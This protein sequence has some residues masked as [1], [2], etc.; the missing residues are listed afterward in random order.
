[1]DISHQ[2]FLYTRSSVN[3]RMKLDKVDN[4]IAIRF[5]H[6][7]S[8]NR[9][10]QLHTHIPILNITIDR[11]GKIKTNECGMIFE[12]ERFIRELYHQELAYNLRQ[13]GYPIIYA[14]KL[15]QLAPEIEGV[16][17]ELM[18]IFSSRRQQIEAYARDHELDLNN[19][20]HM[21]MATLATRKAK[22]NSLAID[23]LSTI[24]QEKVKELG[25]DK[26]KFI[27]E[28]YDNRNG[29]Y[30]A[31]IISDAIAHL[32]ERRVTFSREELIVSALER[33][34]GFHSL[35]VLENEIDRNKELVSG[36]IVMQ[37]Y[38]KHLQKHNDRER[39][40]YSTK[41]QIVT[42]KII[43]TNIVNG[44]G[45]F[46]SIYNK[47]EID[48]FLNKIK[49]NHSIN[50]S[51]K[52]IIE[53]I[54][55]SRDQF[56]G[57]QGYAGVGKTCTMK[58]LSEI[59]IGKNYNLIGLAPTN[60]ATE[61]LTKEAN[62]KTNTLQS[63]LLS[64]NGYANN[65]DGSSIVLSNIRKNFRNKII[66]V[67][68]ASLIGNRQMRDLTTIASKL[69]IRVLLQ[70][71]INQLDS[72]EA[73]TPFQRLIDNR[74]I[75]YVK[76]DKIFRQRNEIL[77][78]AIYAIIDKDIRKSFERLRETKGII[79]LRSDSQ[80]NSELNNLNNIKKDL[81]DTVVAKYFEDRL[82]TL[83]VTSSNEMRK[84]INDSI[85][86][87]LKLENNINRTVTIET[88]EMKQLTRQQK[89]EIAS[90]EMGNRIIFLKSN[91]KTGIEKNREYEIL[92]VYDGT[93]Q[94][95]QNEI[96]I[97]NG[98]NSIIIDVTKQNN[99]NI[100]EKVNREL[101][102]DDQIK[103]TST[104]RERGIVRGNN[105]IVRDIIIK[106]D[107]TRIT[108]FDT[109]INKAIELDTNKDRDILK[110]IDYSYTT[111]TYSSQSKTSRNVIYTLESYRPNL[112]TQKDFYVGISRTRDNITVI[113]DNINRSLQSL[114][115]NSGKQL[116]ANDIIDRSTSMQM[117]SSEAVG[118][119]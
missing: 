33:N 88:L 49:D 34:N 118:L 65:R 45:K 51:Q 87:R 30:E 101:M 67:D 14:R 102:V 115:A 119:G 3:G 7:T 36:N 53:Y 40:L 50:N 22:D 27:M 57:I 104:N 93:R 47:G 108:L 71:D 109:K 25:I 83:I 55:K 61:T 69:N 66:L 28:M 78:E 62:I 63:F 107:T 116:E 5:T 98:N 96:A 56:I 76:L 114:L 11:N 10:P 2:Y 54:L 110:H 64:Y 72:V 20:K 37:E 77:K 113:T 48:G 1:M 24:W 117:N 91:S 81:V 112:T 26:N 21:E 59:L 92:Q 58:V 35:K 52:H 44:R 8:R 103:W 84:V 19:S 4:L 73:G 80:L 38:V 41:T 75:D 18:N 39:I 90:Y 70:G 32:T 17:E 15:T 23:E 89:K 106:E 68:E 43:E 31:S 42:E 9:D 6:H 29:E 105:L 13:L 94:G 85:R 100:Y 12:N 95:E 16:P 97:A 99:L 111:T 46:T 82:N 74:I 79:E 86:Q 60:S